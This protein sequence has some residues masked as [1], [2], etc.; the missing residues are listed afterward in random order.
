MD[1]ASSLTDILQTTGGWGLSGILMVV[2]WRL[3]V[4][5]N[6]KDERIYGLLDKQNDILKLLDRIERKD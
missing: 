1:A 3:W 2:I 6:A 5:N 4:A